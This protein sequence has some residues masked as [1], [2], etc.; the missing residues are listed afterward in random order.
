MASKASIP[1]F[2]LPQYGAIWR[3]AARTVP[4]PRPVNAEL[5]QV[6]V[7]YA[8][9]TAASTTTAA[10]KKSAAATTA[11]KTAA[12]KKVAAPKAAST[13][14][15]AAKTT[16]AAATKAKVTPPKTSPVKAPV[17]KA[18]AS[19]PVTPKTAST[20][21]AKAAVP[22]TSTPAPAAAPKVA[23]KTITPDPSKPI[24]L[25]K[26]ERF[27]PPSHGSRLPRSI[28]KHYGGAPTMEE[29]TAQQK[30]Q[31][32]GLPPPP[33]TWSHWFLNNRHIHMFI[34]LGTLLSL[35]FYTFA[36]KFNATSPYA[37]MIPA[38]SEFW[39]HPI[40]YIGTCLHVLKLHE[41]HISAETAEKRRRKVDDVA[42]RNEYRKAHGLDSAQGIESWTGPSQPAP[43]APAAAPAEAPAEQKQPEVQPDLYIDENGK[44]KKFWGIF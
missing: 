43:L 44:R 18:P 8:S 3:T 7:R 22:K 1:R 5:G 6:L 15:T 21:T 42:K 32:P 11:S 28:P 29:V 17:T 38:F 23:P 27:N 37:D 41:E 9:K 14:A 12:A 34:T 20:A 35:A 33:N 26:P 19:K 16:S 25:E 2:L 40:D 4:F 36:A 39:S 24:V 31:Y 30:K 10:A 13:K